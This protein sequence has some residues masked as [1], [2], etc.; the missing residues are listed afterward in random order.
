MEFGG[1]LVEMELKKF[2]KRLRENGDYYF[3]LWMLSAIL[4]MGM[5]FNFYAITSNDGRMPVESNY[6]FDTERHFSFQ[7]KD[8]VKFYY[9]T[10]IIKLPFTIVSIGDIIIVIGLGL[11]TIIVIHMSNHRKKK[12]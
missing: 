10:D 9:L 4:M 2:R 5:V 12:K 8:E 3:V 6:G 1:F 7:N 11:M